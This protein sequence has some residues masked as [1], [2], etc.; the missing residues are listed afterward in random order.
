M[1]ELKSYFHDLHVNDHCKNEMAS[2]PSSDRVVEDVFK[3][4]TEVKTGRKKVKSQINS[5]MYIKYVEVYL[6]TQQRVFMSEFDF[7]IWY[8]WIINNDV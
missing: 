6:S 5:K 3:T 7:Y 2:H 4:F 1:Q 8:K